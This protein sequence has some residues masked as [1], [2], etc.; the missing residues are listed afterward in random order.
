MM[1]FGRQEKA[2]PSP[3]RKPLC[4]PLPRTATRT[5]GGRLERG[6]VQMSPS[7]ECQADL[8]VPQTLKPSGLIC[9]RERVVS[10]PFDAQVGRPAPTQQ[11]QIPIIWT[12]PSVNGEGC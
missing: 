1:L 3:T 2:T 5:R 4:L 7:S 11:T 8:P 9:R 12:P 10:S 6:E